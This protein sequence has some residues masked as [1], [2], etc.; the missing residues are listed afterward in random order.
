MPTGF[1]RRDTCE[2]HARRCIHGVGLLGTVKLLLVVPLRARYPDLAEGIQ[3]S[4]QQKKFT[5]AKRYPPVRLRLLTLLLLNLQHH[6][7]G[8]TYYIVHRPTLNTYI[9]H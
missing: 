6:R 5:T 4:K 8:P 9:G 3:N 1:Q 2:Y 7:P